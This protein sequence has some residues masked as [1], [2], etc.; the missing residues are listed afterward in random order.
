M[1]NAAIKTLL[2]FTL[3]AIALATLPAHAGKT[4]DGI[5]ARGQL[6]CGVNTGVA[7]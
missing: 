7:G 2:A 1:K 3:G 5:K 4:I 6:T